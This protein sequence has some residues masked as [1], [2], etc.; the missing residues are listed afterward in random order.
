MQEKFVADERS[1]LNTLGDFARIV[2][3]KQWSRIGEVFADDVTFN[4]GDGE[5][6]QGMVALRRQFTKYLD[7]C[8]PSQHL[9][10]SVQIELDGDQAVTRAYV[11]A[12]HLGKDDKAQ[13][14]FDTNGEYTDRWARR[15]E[16]WRIVRREARWDLFMGDSSVLFPG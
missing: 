12:R 11:Q 5:E 4:Y 13:L 8:G 3:R 15:A 6:Q 7:L 9:L 10:G 14:C 1:I 2:D 16:G